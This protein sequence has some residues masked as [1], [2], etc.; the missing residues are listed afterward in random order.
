M[1]RGRAAIDG[2]AVGRVTILSEGL[3]EAKHVFAENKRGI[4]A[5]VLYR[6]VNFVLYRLVLGF[7]IKKWNLHGY[8]SMQ[9][10]GHK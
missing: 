1:Q 6:R 9:N 3:L 4:S 2:D 8:S 10:D 5:N 7:Q